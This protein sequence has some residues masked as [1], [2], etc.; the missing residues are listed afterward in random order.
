MR[1]HLMQ[2]RCISVRRA[3]LPADRAYPAV[4]RL[5]Q[6]PAVDFTAHLIEAVRW[7]RHSLL[8][9]THRRLSRRARR[10][11]ACEPV[12]RAWGRARLG[13]FA[14]GAAVAL[15]AVLLYGILAPGTP[16]LTAQDVKDSIASALA[17]VTPP[18]AFSEL[19]YQIVQP[20]LVLIQTEAA[21]RGRPNDDPGTASGSG[22]VV[23][24]AA[25]SSPASTSSPMRRRS[26]DLRRR[27]SRPAEIVT[28]QPEN[29]IAVLRADD[30]AGRRR[31]G[32]LGDPRRDAH[33]RA[34]R[35]SSAIRSGCTA[36]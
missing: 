9:Q 20:S 23:N 10:T 35:S 25:T 5:R 31:P 1:R 28:P 26:A 16:P 13:P 18:P 32:D 12:A 7:Q 8:D 21:T 27:H 30:A 17:S 19:V 11:R 29:D 2:P 36:R 6:T 4:E 34:R 15:G 33:R 14:A 24:A 22:V 3:C